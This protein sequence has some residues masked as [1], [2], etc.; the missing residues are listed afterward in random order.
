MKNKKDWLHTD[1][2]YPYMNDE[3]RRLYGSGW[4]HFAKYSYYVRKA[5]E[6]VNQSD[7]ENANRPPRQKKHRSFVKSILIF[8]GVLFLLW[9][10]GQMML[11][12]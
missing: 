3:E 10:L 1:P 11:T 12:V 5:A 9:L 6:S 7:A 8:I 4:K 2:D